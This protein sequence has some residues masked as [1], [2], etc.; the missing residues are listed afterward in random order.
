[1]Q[2]SPSPY[3]PVHN[4]IAAVMAH[5]LRYAFRPQ[6][7]LSQ[8]SG[9]S[10]AVISRLI[11]G[12]SRPQYLT[13]VRISL[14]LGRSAG[15]ILPMDELFSPDGR[16]PTAS[17]CELTGCRRCSLTGNPEGHV[18]SIHRDHTQ[19]RLVGVGIGRW[20][21]LVDVVRQ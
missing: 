5:T 3:R 10:Q 16:Y 1:M 7:R 8:D 20:K 17:V 14:A 13:A 4:R 9:I 19:R 12:R 18:A 6:A 11:A 2:G 15:T 21:L